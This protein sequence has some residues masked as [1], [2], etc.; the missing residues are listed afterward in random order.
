MD[1]IRTKRATISITEEELK[2]A[3]AISQAIFG[4]I[5]FSGIVRYWIRKHNKQ[6]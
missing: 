6:Q 5:N 4:H 2:K 3:K 1:K